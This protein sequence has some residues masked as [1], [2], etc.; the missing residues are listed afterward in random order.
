M[1]NSTDLLKVRNVVFGVADGLE[2]DGLRLVVNEL[3]EVFRLVAGDEFRANPESG[4]ENFELVVG[5]TVQ[6]RGADDVVADRAESCK[7]H[8]LRGLAGGGSYCGLSAFESGDTFLK[9]IDRR[10]CRGE[11]R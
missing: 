3:L 2:E 6:V 1:C 5:T 4:Q 10:L 9:H 7:G 11:P 8:E